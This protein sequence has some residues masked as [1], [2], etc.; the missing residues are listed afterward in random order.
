MY[1]K[2]CLFIYY[3]SPP[4]QAGADKEGPVADA[5]AASEERTES[6]LA[7]QRDRLAAHRLV[8]HPHRHADAESSS[9]VQELGGVAYIAAAAHHAGESAESADGD[10]V[11]ESV[12]GAAAVLL[13]E[14]ALA[15][16]AL[17]ATEHVR[18]LLD[19]PAALESGVPR[20]DHESLDSGRTGAY[21]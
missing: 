12:D 10:D 11:D 14:A 19:T 17:S 7:G 3:Y 15:S 20:Q 8:L 9:N 2:V 16:A 4:L 5:T 18:E 1:T 6:P 13:D 21:H